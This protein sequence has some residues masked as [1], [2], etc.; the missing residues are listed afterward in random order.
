MSFRLGDYVYP[1][2]LPRR[3]PCR[4]EQ[5]ETFALPSGVTQLL[6]LVPLAG[7]WP[8]G[9][10]LIRLGDTV[11]PIATSELPQTMRATTC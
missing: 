2:D 1:T 7:P 9:T 11:A 8:A 3:F 10:E 6:R 5:T 4:I